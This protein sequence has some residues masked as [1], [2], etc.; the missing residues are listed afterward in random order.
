MKKF[1]L[2]ML[3]VLFT[4]LI[5]ISSYAQGIWIADSLMPEVAPSTEIAMGITGLSCMHS[6]VSNVVGKGDLEPLAIEYEGVTYDNPTMI[7]GVTNGMFYAW[8]TAEEGTFVLYVKMSPNKK[9]F[10]IELTSSC[11]GSSDLA[12][13]TTNF[14]TANDITGNNS[15]FT[16]PTVYDTYSQ[17]ENTWDGN[18]VAS[19]E[20]T[21]I[22]FSWPVKANK[23]YVTG[24]F[25][26]KM[27]VKAAN[28]ITAASGLENFRTVQ[29]PDIFPNPATGNVFVKMDRSTEIGIYNTAGILLKQQLVT[30]SDNMV[31]IS[32]LESGLYFIRDI[33][34]NNKAQ[35]LIVK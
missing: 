10:I 5:G 20:G 1:Y 14:S 32:G 27:M 9:T 23:T 13:L 28:Y 18:A 8:R 33:S 21:H 34:G 22:V 24:C 17:A 26:S 12:T 30:P 19:T 29:L 31:D 16:T 25:G 6:D 3:S 15:Y 7:Q 11:P 2:T 4:G 35:K